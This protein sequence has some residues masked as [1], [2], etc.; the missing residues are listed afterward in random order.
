MSQHDKQCTLCGANTHRA[1]RC[2]MR[3]KMVKMNAV[4]LASLC[5]LLIQGDMN[6][7]EL[8]EETGLHYV[9]VLN[10]TRAMHKKGAVH[11]ARWDADKNGRHLVKVYKLGPGKDA[12][13][14]R[15]TDSQRSEKYR[16]KKLAALQL[17]VMTGKATCVQAANGRLQYTR[18]P[19]AA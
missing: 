13:R 1:N 4:S 19:E 6:C 14:V 9:T 12:K 3:P 11:I 7:M 17:A 8:A 2:P 15:Q 10:Y 16:A 5:F 18:V